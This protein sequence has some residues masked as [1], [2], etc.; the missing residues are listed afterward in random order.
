MSAITLTTDLVAV[1]KLQSS[2]DIA[3]EPHNVLFEKAFL[4]ARKI[5]ET[6]DVDSKIT[7][8]IR[9]YIEGAAEIGSTLLEL[10]RVRS[11]DSFSRLL[12]LTEYF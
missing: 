11:S 12:L 8:V 3:V 2:F 6:L 5:L 7:P 1:D 9:S 10:S 4:A